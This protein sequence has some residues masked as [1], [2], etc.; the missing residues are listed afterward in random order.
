MP[1]SV[2]A[3]R[4]RSRKFGADTDDAISTLSPR[5]SCCTMTRRSWSPNGSGS[6]MNELTSANIAVAPAIPSASD[7][8]ATVDTTG[9]LISMRKP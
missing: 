9:V 7:S 4:S 5:R 3:A 1:A 8:A 6:S 2:V